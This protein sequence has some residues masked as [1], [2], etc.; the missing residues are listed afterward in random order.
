[1]G[2]FPISLL[3]FNSS[4]EFVM[5]FAKYSC[6][7][8]DSSVRLQSFSLIRSVLHLN[9]RVLHVNHRPFHL[10]CWV[11]SYSPSSSPLSLSTLSYSLTFST[12]LQS[13]TRL[14][15]DFPS[16]FSSVILLTEFSIPFTRFIVLFMQFFILYTELPCYSP[17]FKSNIT[18]SIEFVSFLLSSPTY[19]TNFKRYSRAFPACFLSVILFIEF[20]IPLTWFTV[21]FAQFFILFTELLLFTMLSV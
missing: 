10:I 8:L 11:L 4:A 20:S 16:R 17:C 15:Q 1:M 7:S 9:H 21:L 3:S 19:S 5:L 13:F 18:L 14:S 6:Y 12:Y 2:S